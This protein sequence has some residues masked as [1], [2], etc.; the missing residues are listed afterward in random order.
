MALWEAAGRQALLDV[1]NH[2]RV[3]ADVG[4]GAG[5]VELALVADRVA[6][7]APIN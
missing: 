6:S 5:G 1:E 4:D 7:D 3:A 2:V